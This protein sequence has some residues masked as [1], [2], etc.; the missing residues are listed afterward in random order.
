MGSEAKSRKRTRLETGEKSNDEATCR[1][2]TTYHQKMG[3]KPVL[4]AEDQ[5]TFNK[6][7]SAYDYYRLF[8]SVSFE[9]KNCV[10]VKIECCPEGIPKITLNN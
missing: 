7:S 4:D 1:Q 5:A 8:Q 9:N 6:L 2:E 10:P 3:H